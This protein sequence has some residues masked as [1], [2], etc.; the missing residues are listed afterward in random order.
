MEINFQQLRAVMRSFVADVTQKSAAA[1]ITEASLRLSGHKSLLVAIVREDGT[2][3]EAAWHNNRQQL[4]RWLDSDS[5]R[6]K[7]RIAELYPAILAALPPMLRAQLVASKSISYLAAQA[8]KEHLEAIQAI[9]LGGSKDV[10]ARE[11]EEAEQAL[12]VLKIAAGVRSA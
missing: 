3:D 6:S 1:Q 9:T 5:T 11:C 2:V 4:F 10:I 12:R 7:K 8:Q